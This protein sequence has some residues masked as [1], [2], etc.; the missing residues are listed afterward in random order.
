MSDFENLARARSYLAKAEAYLLECNFQ[1]AH[2]MLEAAEAVINT[3]RHDINDNYI[4]KPR[5][6]HGKT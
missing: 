1:K 2:G 5:L 6:H 3:L 4:E